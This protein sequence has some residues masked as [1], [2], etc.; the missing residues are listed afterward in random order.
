[1][2]ALVVGI[3]KF[4]TPLNELE[5]V[6]KPSLHES[7]NRYDLI[8]VHLLEGGLNKINRLKSS[9]SIEHSCSVTKWTIM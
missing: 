6:L 9:L 7:I 4:L 8:D 1:M 2:L 5:V 3:K